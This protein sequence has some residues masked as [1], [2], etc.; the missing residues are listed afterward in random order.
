VQRYVASA[1]PRPQARTTAT[2]Y[3]P[4]LRLTHARHPKR[5]P[6][7]PLDA[8]E[9]DLTAAIAMPTTRA[10][11]ETHK[12]SPSEVMIGGVLMPSILAR[13]NAGNQRDR[14]VINSR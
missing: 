10:A 2:D 4:R 14:A 7:L 8:G 11:T 1:N 9:D 5:R 12:D 13:A 3:R 6:T